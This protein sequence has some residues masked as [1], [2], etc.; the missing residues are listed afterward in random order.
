MICLRIL[1][2]NIF[3]NLALSMMQQEQMRSSIQITLRTTTN[4][5]L[6]LQEMP[7]MK[8]YL[9]HQLEVR[10]FRH[11]GYKFETNPLLK[12]RTTIYGM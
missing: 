5:S 1:F 4:V 7:I 2:L 10:P 11:L 9:N 3:N 6:L 8:V 12:K